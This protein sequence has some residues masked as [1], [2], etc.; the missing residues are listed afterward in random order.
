MM[1]REMNKGILASA[2]ALVGGVRDHAESLSASAHAG[3]NTVARRGA[4]AGS[5]AA[6]FLGNADT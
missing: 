4:Q 3:W 1:R 2:A 5:E 6:R